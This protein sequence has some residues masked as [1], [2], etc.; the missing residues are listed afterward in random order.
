[1]C[2]PVSSG[3][4]IGS[5]G[6]LSCLRNLGDGIVIE[7]GGDAGCAEIDGYTA[8]ENHRFGVIHVDAT[9]ADEFDRE[10]AEGRALLKG[11]HNLLEMLR[12]HVLYYTRKVGGSHCFYTRKG[13]TSLA[14]FRSVSYRH[15]DSDR[16]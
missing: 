12:S 11:T 3:F 2:C 10:R 14:V 4:P 9:S 15:R 5:S 1:M 6:P 16:A 13:V 7:E 8:A